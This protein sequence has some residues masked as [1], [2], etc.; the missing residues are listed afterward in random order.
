MTNSEITEIP[1]APVETEQQSMSLTAVSYQTKLLVTQSIFQW[2]SCGI[3]IT[4]NLPSVSN[5]LDPLFLIR[6]N[7]L[8]LN[9]N[10]IVPRNRNIPELP[11]NQTVWTASG[12]FWH[13]I[14][15]VFQANKISHEGVKVTYY[16]Q[17]PL[18]AYYMLYHRWWTGSLKWKLTTTASFI[19]QGQILAVPLF[20]SIQP[21][22]ICTPQKVGP[23]GVAY[24]KSPEVNSPGNQQEV[25]VKNSFIRTDVSSIRHMEIAVPYRSNLPYFDNFQYMLD[26]MPQTDNVMTSDFDQVDAWLQDTTKTKTKLNPET[27]IAIYNKNQ[28]NAT[29]T[30]GTNEIVFELWIAAGEDFQ[31]GGQHVVPDFSQYRYTHAQGIYNYPDSEA[32]G[33]RDTLGNG[34]DFD[35]P[36]V[37]E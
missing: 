19:N 26:A 32:S 23:D 13:M 4:V 15:P 28:I 18:L 20:N 8:V 11:W 12:Y 29:N 33:G 9:P 31:M 3:R 35:R 17:P 25:K 36:I 22:Q 27:F 5:N 6:N 30:S 37:T 34:V 2:M 7:P 14:M 1:A 10:L 24:F 16:G 21:P